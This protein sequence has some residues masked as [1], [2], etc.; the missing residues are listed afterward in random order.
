M[1]RRVSILHVFN[2]EGRE[3]SITP[4]QSQAHNTYAK[5]AATLPVGHRAYISVASKQENDEWLIEGYGEMRRV[6]LNGYTYPLHLAT[7]FPT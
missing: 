5:A 6:H 3:L 7:E 4:K 1:R 2:G